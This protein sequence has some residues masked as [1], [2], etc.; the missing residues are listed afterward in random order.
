MIGF[1]RLYLGVHFVTDVLAGW[2]L[3]TAW[4]ATVIL[5]ASWWSHSERPR[6]LSVRGRTR[7]NLMPAND[8]ERSH[9][10]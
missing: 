3:G 6:I 9:Q 4:T 8:P 2:L 10:T 7:S 1:S 5:V